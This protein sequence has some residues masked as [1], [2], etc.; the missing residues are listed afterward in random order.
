MKKFLSLLLALSILFVVSGCSC[1]HEWLNATCITSATCAK[2]GEEAGVPLGHQWE[3]A[4]CTTPKVCMICKI[5][6]GKAMGHSWLDATCQSPKVCTIC[7]AIEGEITDHSWMD[8]TCQSPKVCVTC[9]LTEGTQISHVYVNGQCTTCDCRQL[10]VGKWRS[11]YLV[12]DQLNIV[13]ID[14][15]TFFVFLTGYYRVDT[16]DSSVLA[17]CM[18]YNRKI[19]T[20]EGI[21]YIDCLGDGVTI[22]YEII[23]ETIRMSYEDGLDGRVVFE[24]IAP[25][26]IKVVEV[27]GSSFFVNKDW[28]FTYQADSATSEPTGAEVTTTTPSTEPYLTEPPSTTQSTT[29]SHSWE[30][31]SCT[32]AKTC[33]ICSATEGKANGHDWK[34]AT[35]T[36]PKTCAMCSETMG[37]ENSH[38]YFNGKCIDCGDN[39]PNYFQ[40]TM[41]WIPTH[42]GTKYHRKSSCSK[43]KDPI[44]VTKTEAIDRGFEPCGKCY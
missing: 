32:K 17:N 35:C 2:C 43:M 21:E 11:Y 28:V 23:S 30:A 5:T 33:K 15:D 9:R 18:Q 34:D 26:Q 40:E 44:Q 8:A 37:T 31:A 1:E 12:N 19:V 36:S 39:D 3:D 24:R 16:L 29:C 7:E 41:V 22:N 14:F 4:T 25:Q 6:E 10:G 13:D 42:G 38:I 20:Y 27:I